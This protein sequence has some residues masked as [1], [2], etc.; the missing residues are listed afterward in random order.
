MSRSAATV[1]LDRV[2]EA[3][4]RYWGFDKLRPLQQEA[5][6]AGIDQR[7]SLLVM[8]TGGGKSLCYQVPPLLANRTDIVISPLISIMKDQVD[9]LRACGY[10]AAAIHGNMS[11]DEIRETENDIAAGKYRLIFVAPERLFASRFM[12]L[13]ERI[14]VRAFAIDEAHCISHWGHDFRP[15][16]RQLAALRDRFPKTSFHAF[17]A[18]ATQRVRDD[19][20]AQLKLKDPRV[21]VGV[22]DRPNLVYRIV[23]RVDVYTQTAKAL[24]RHKDES[25]I[26]YCISRKDTEAMA[27][28]LRSC[29][30]KA[31]HYH[32]GM[33]S[34]D[35]RRVQDEFAQEKIDVVVATVAFGM[36]IDRSNV[37]CVIHA[38]MPKSVEHYQQETGRAGRDGLEAECLLF[39][40]AGDVFK[41]ESLI[42]RS[43]E[44]AEKPADV[45][46]AAK[47]LLRHMQTYCSGM[48]CRHKSLTEYFGQTYSRDAC[49][50][51]DVCLKEME[52]VAD[53]TVTA[54]KILSCV[55][56]LDR[57]FGAG[58]VADILAGAN[59]EPIR[60][61]G[62]DRLSTYGLL[63]DFDR[64]QLMNYV[65]QLVDQGVLERAGDE[66]P[67]LQLNAASWSVMRGDQS[68]SL[69]Q[70]K[71][72]GVKKTKIDETS[73][74]G[75]DRG[76]FDALRT[77]RQAESAKR[78]VPA[79][80]IFGDA[81]L[82]ELARRRPSTL[83]NLARIKG[84]GERKLK[85][86]GPQF[87]A[88]IQK[89]CTANGI[90]VDVEI[91]TP[92]DLPPRPKRP[93]PSPARKN[94]FAMFKQGK[95]IEEVMQATDRA[96]S[97][98]CQYLVEFIE[99]EK[100]ST[101]AHWVDH[102]IK[103]RIIAAINQCGEGSLRPIFDHLDGA[104]DYET[105]KTVATHYRVTQT[106]PQ[107]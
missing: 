38:A 96:R 57:P 93:N 4:K 29:K 83:E 2:I 54:Q 105:I 19:I 69:L 8:P 27:E 87:L 11:F 20:V 34:S 10:P 107:K 36:G 12:Q 51:C 68:V 40:S 80:V 101:I 98:T 84:V 77:L 58:Y 86:L 72:D 45:I 73:W 6:L 55:A 24:Q 67:V 42:E 70:P 99:A 47:Q 94:A 78:A 63:R 16:Y 7:D 56:R 97:T 64:K 52:S 61:R 106:N 26:V 74:E 81:T 9:G 60:Q 15:E 37:R 49:G 89:Y 44:E 31:E 30:I 28:Y 35:R 46:T 43:A 90:G 41:W 104:I 17:T 53:S 1:S 88:C 48:R 13:I 66:Y 62:H 71:S 79:Y 92:N 18:T 59:T 32:A 5:I 33:E 103:Q 22:F 82:R 91:E 76:L 21:L 95:S 23:P 3:T 75:V 100:P 85:D 25:A 14:G 50:A 65:H 102:E 39:Y